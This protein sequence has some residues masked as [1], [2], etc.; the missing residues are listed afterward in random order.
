MNCCLGGSGPRA[1][2]LSLGC[3]LGREE[4]YVL[5]KPVHDS[6]QSLGVR[7]EA[8]LPECLGQVL[9]LQRVAALYA[10]QDPAFFLGRQGSGDGAGLEEAQRVGGDRGMGVIE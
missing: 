8:G 10:L 9:S 2:L 3:H 5:Q 4:S 1:A 7:G 6:P